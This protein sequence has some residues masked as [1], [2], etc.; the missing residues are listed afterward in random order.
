MDLVN[1]KEFNDIVTRTRDFSACGV[2]PQP[3]D[4]SKIESTSI[5]TVCIRVG[6]PLCLAMYSVGTGCSFRG[7]EEAWWWS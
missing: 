7:G 5:I 1:G 2:A 6:D 4:V 3:R